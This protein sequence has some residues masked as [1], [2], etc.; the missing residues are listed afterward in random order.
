MNPIHRLVPLL[1]AIGSVCFWGQVC[2]AVSPDAAPV[3]HT[4]R[5]EILQD[6]SESAATNMEGETDRL[7]QATTINPY[8]YADM[9]SEVGG[10]IEEFFFEEGDLIQ[11]GDVVVQISKQRYGLLT[12]KASDAAEGMEL[13][14]ER[15]EQHLKVIQQLL[16][17]DAATRQELLQAEADV[18]IAQT[19]LKQ[20]KKE[21]NLATLNLDACRVKA[22]FTGYLVTRYKQPHEPVERLEKIFSIVDNARVYAVA[23]VAANLVS[24]FAKGSQAV[25]IDSSGKAFTGTVDRVAKIIDAKSNTRRVYVLIDNSQ[26][27]LEVGM[28]GFLR[29]KRPG[30]P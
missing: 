9:G 24:R 29:P 16:A 22:P 13:A 19:N 4:P 14:C 2:Q 5:L 11:K 3:S 18:E 6:S 27:D 8:Q 17:Q 12:E 26:G 30:S 10:I 15:A 25:F 21:F 28:T 1:L 7:L 23:N 20:A